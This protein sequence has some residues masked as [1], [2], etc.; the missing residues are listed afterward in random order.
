MIRSGKYDFALECLESYLLDEIE[1]TEDFLVSLQNGSWSSNIVANSNE[2]FQERRTFVRN[3]LHDYRKERG[4]K[5]IYK[6]EE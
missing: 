5:P 3:Y 2:K 6:K 1:G 4:S